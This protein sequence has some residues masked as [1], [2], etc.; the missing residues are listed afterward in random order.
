MKILKELDDEKLVI[1]DLEVKLQLLNL[2]LSID[3]VFLHHR[4]DIEWLLI[5]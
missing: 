4:L 5:R 2:P 1:V 3:A